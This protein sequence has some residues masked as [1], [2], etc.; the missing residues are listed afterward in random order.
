MAP[1]IVG[2][3][4]L[5][6]IEAPGEPIRHSFGGS[7]SF[8]SLAAGLFGPVRLIGAVGDDFPDEFRAIL[9]AGRVDLRGLSVYPGEKMF[10]W[11]GRYQTDRNL[12]ETVGLELNVIAVSEPTIPPEFQDSPCVL[13]ANMP[14]A[15]QLHALAQLRGP[16]FV[17]V[18]TVDDWIIAHRA[19]LIEVMNRVDAVLM[20]D[21][22]ARLL[23]GE[24]NLIR[25]AHAVRR[26]G[27]RRLIVKKGEHGCALFDDAGI[28]LL[29]AYP[30][31]D[32]V[33]P[34][35]A[36]DAF[37]G[38][39]LGFLAT[40]D[41]VTPAALRR[42]LRSGTVIASIAV[43]GHGF[44]T[45]SRLGRAEVDARLANYEQMLIGP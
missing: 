11:H 26:L 32:D 37:A 22:E 31:P 34:T 24:A 15:K 38:G 45:L 41:A 2:T 13:I 29:P 12:R 42:A 1:L 28:A 16:Q 3:L 5:D 23:A 36:G 10:R 39:T 7:G 19:E 9:E 20:N 18:D 25:A 33:D 35:G 44:A 40:C 43:E 30:T 4:A 27:A 6:T 14:P 8:S 21:S 17:M